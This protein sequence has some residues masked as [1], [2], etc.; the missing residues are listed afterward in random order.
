MQRRKC[1]PPLN[2]T[3]RTAMVIP[4]IK[5]LS[6]IHSKRQR[7]FFSSNIKSSEQK[8]KMELYIHIHHV[9]INIFVYKIVLAKA[10]P[11]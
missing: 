4:T 3:F 9:Q 8:L 2:F 10:T 11:S 6:L 1:I 5:R 7:K